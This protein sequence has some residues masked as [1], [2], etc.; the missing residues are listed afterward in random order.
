MYILSECRM[1]TF[2]AVN[3]LPLWRICGK[4]DKQCYV[5]FTIYQTIFGIF[6]KSVCCN[7]FGQRSLAGCILELK[8]EHLCTS[9]HC[10]VLNVPLLYARG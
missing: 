10:L 2:G 9:M 7:I 4:S 3:M 8:T 5:I 6:P 1:T